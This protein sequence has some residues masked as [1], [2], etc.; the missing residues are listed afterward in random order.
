MGFHKLNIRPAISGGY[1]ARGGWLT[2]RYETCEDLVLK[3]DSFEKSGDIQP[4]L[5]FRCFR[6]PK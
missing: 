4:E 5:K 2:S 3:P 1:V 6:Y